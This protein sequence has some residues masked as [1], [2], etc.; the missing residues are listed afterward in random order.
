MSRHTKT[1]FICIALIIFALFCPARLKTK[2]P[3]MFNSRD[4]SAS[5]FEVKPDTP[6]KDLTESETEEIIDEIQN[7]RAIRC[8]KPKYI[9]DDFYKISIRYSGKVK[10]ITYVEGKYIAVDNSWYRIF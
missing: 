8:I 1:I 5:Y 2:Y 10:Q 9:S 4:V 7:L 6:I 3:L